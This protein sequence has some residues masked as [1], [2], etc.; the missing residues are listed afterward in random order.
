MRRIRFSAFAFDDEDLELYWKRCLHSRPRYFYGYVSMLTDFADYIARRG[1]DGRRLGLK[2]IITTAE[3]LTTPQRTLL[4]EVFGAPVQNEYG[5]GEAGAIAYEC[6]AGALHVISENVVVE[7]LTED[8]RE[9]APGEAGK[10]I[11]TDLH[12]RAMPLVRYALGDIAVRGED[13]CACGRGFPVLREVRGRE[14]EFVQDRKGRRFHGEFFM[15]LFEDL[16]DRG[17]G[18]ERFRIRQTGESHVDIEVESA[19]PLSRR[20]VA[21]IVDY[22]GNAASGLN[23]AVRRVASIPRAPSGKS[24]IVVNDWFAERENGARS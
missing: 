21:F 4:R 10:V 5:C 9:A 14:Y 7:L 13:S 15:Y 23:T 2:L 6:E 18:V 3:A 19:E 22:L 12:N 1:H 11:L 16:R 17:M 20:Q 8:G 24:R